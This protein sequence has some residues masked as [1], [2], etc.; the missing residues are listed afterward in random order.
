MKKEEY[1]NEIP[2]TEK[3]RPSKLS[4]CVLPLRISKRLEKWKLK[5]PNHLIFYGKAGVGKTSA[6]LALA[7]E[8]APDDYII[9]NA[10]KD[11]DDNFINSYVTKLMRG[12]SL[13]G[14][15]RIIILDES[16]RLTENA[17][18]SLRRP[19]EEFSHLCSIIFTFNYDDKVIEPIKSRCL[20]FD[21]NLEDNEK[22]EVKK[23]LIKRLKIIIEKEKKDISKKELDLIVNSKFPD[24]RR[25]LNELEV[26]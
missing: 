19:L 12:I 7:K 5:Q 22:D 11:N 17:Q 13:Y 15:K 3:Y 25:C 26:Y 21:F 18:T 24:M 6:A 14:Q 9:I 1:F 4:E 23:S 2:L 16:D 8:L 20:E 10:S